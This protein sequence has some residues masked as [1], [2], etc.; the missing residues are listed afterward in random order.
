MIKGILVRYLAFNSGKLIF[1]LYVGII[2]KAC[3]LYMLDA[4]LVFFLHFE[5]PV[6]SG[7]SYDTSL[8]YALHVV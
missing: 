2:V 6:S 8:I 5:A 7:V 3:L 1:R 4:S